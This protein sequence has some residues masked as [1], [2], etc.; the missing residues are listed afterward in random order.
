MIQIRTADWKNQTR[1]RTV[2]NPLYKEDEIY[3]EAIEL[4][5][6]YWDREPIR[7]LGITVSN[8]IPMNEIYEQLSIYNFE[9]H[10]EAEQLDSL[11]KKIEQKFGPGSIKRGHS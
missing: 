11:V 10:A 5:K 1:S 9:K 4:F 7:L 3:N 6:L 8:V 2:L